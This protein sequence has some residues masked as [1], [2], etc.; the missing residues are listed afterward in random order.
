MYCEAFAV[1]P[2]HSIKCTMLG[3]HSARQAHQ[4]CIALRQPGL[5]SAESMAQTICIRTIG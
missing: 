1:Y 5:A 2:E 3:Q 4:A